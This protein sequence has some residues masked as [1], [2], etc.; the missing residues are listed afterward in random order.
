MKTE[1]KIPHQ[2]LTTEVVTITDW[3]V[4][5]KDPVKE[6]DVLLNIESEKAQLEIEAPVSGIVIKIIK[7]AGEEAAIDEVVAIIES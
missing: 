4:K 7:A 6:G 1:I 3:V 5:E 2:G